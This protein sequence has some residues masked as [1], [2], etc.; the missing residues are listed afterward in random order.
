MLDEA[1]QTPHGPAGKVV[2]LAAGLSHLIAC[3]LLLAVMFLVVANVVGRRFLDQPVPGAQELVEVG[4][5]ALVWLGMGHAQLRG[6]H[7][8]VDLLFHRA[9]PRVTALVDALAYALCTLVGVVLVR[10][11]VAYSGVMD[12]GGY[13]TAVWHVPVSAV[14]LVC[15]AGAVVWTAALAL[16]TAGAALTVLGKETTHA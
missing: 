12:R 4:I 11:F 8:I 5:A 1:P 2:S 16:E 3:V 6:D 10:Q 7:I 14:A 15:A 13:E 9:K